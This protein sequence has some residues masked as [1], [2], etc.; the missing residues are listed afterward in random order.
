MFYSHQVLELSVEGTKFVLK[1]FIPQYILSAVILMHT[2][3]L[4][5]MRPSTSCISVFALGMILYFISSAHPAFPG[6]LQ[7]CF[8]I[9]FLTETCMYVCV[10]V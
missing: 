2:V 7:S 3:H 10:C 9:S 1:C 8:A 4:W 5:P 6:T